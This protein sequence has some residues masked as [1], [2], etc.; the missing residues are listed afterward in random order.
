M[1]SRLAGGRKG[2]VKL[3]K[4][5]RRKTKRVVSIFV[6]KLAESLEFPNRKEVFLL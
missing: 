6:E 4:D 5:N 3:S 2:L 1:H